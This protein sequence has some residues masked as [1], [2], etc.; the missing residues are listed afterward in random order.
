[1]KCFIKVSL[2][3]LYVAKPYIR[4][5]ITLGKGTLTFGEDLDMIIA[6]VL[7]YSFL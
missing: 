3:I 4:A 1:M 2:Q 6:P 5:I 7:N